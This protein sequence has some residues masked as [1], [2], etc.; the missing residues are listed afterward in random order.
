MNKYS[1]W[2]L[3]ILGALMVGGLAVAGGDVDA[4]REKAASCAGCHGAAGEGMG[5]N[6][7]LAGLDRDNLASVM[8]EYT[9]GERT[10]PMM[11]MIMQ[12]LSDED[13]ADLAAYYASLPG[14]E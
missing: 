8:K 5:E 12:G 9:T 13:I 10:G 2:Q 11:T 6:P 4:G 1:L 14:A 7:A 3:V